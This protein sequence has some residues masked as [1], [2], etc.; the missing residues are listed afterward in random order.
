[1][2]PEH[3]LTLFPPSAD[4]LTGQFRA[5]TR[6]ETEAW[7]HVHLAK[8]SLINRVQYSGSIM[9]IQTSTDQMSIDFN[10]PLAQSQISYDGDQPRLFLVFDGYAVKQR[11]AKAASESNTLYDDHL[12]LDMATKVSAADM[13]RLA[14]GFQT[15]ANHWATASGGA[16]A[17]FGT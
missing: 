17:L 3:R 5:P 8:W 15:L 10:V 6:A 11:P 4:V 14:N 2:K 12:V 1:M 16:N 9:T 13:N 7:I